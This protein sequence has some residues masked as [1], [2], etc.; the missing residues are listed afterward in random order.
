MIK[1]GLELDAL[2]ADLS[3]AAGGWSLCIGSGTSAPVFPS[4]SDLVTQLV[5]QDSLAD[6]D[7]AS[8]L[9]K[10]CSL[11]SL[12][13]A[14]STVLDTGGMGF[15]QWLAAHL[16]ADL[17][18]KA[19]DQWPELVRVLQT[20]NIGAVPHTTWTKFLQFF[21]LHYPGLTALALAE[22]VTEVIDTKH[23]PMEILS[24]NAEP[25]FLGLANALLAARQDDWNRT[26]QSAP[27]QRFD[28]IT[29]ST[30]SRRRDRIPFLF[31]HGLL[32][33]PGSTSTHVDHDS[34][35]KLVFSEG[36]YLALG[37]ELVSWQAASFVAACLTRRIV[38]VGVSLTDSNM[39][40][41]LFRSFQTRTR[42]L[43]TINGRYYGGST[44]H[45]WLNKQTH[46]SRERQWIEASVAQLGVRL[47]WLRDWAEA[48]PALRK[49]LR[50]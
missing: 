34:V 22:V 8:R 41:W 38:F 30:S 9:L 2:N 6:P 25:V 16:Y 28:K 32:R 45:F 42:E 24:F 46:T 27:L 12:I 33:A 44:P 48:G 18:A 29:R 47:V 20:E 11:E 31:C 35:D 17:Q 1:D 39:R 15:G 19:A 4:W 36:Q 21:R 40:A 37:N 5:G 7:L 23:A 3:Q 10:Q 50:H 43:K 26:G 49:L 14:A 13:E